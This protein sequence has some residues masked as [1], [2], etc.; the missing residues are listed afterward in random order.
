MF[1]SLVPAQ[2]ATRICI[3]SN[4]RIYSVSFW[5]EH[6]AADERAFFFFSFFF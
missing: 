4:T 2:A 5:L 1:S 3:S 6:A